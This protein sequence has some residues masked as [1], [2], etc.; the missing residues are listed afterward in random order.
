MFW[1]Y[2]NE[3]QYFIESGDFSQ[4]KLLN[5]NLYKSYFYDKVKVLEFCY[6]FRFNFLIYVIFHVF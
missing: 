4:I 5:L 6:G 1:K 3:F 2:P